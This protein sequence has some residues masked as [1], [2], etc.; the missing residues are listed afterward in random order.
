MARSF[1]LLLLGIGLGCIAFAYQ[2]WICLVA[3]LG[4]DFVILGVAHMQGAHQVFGKRADGSLPLWSW[5]IFLPM[6][7]YSLVTLNLARSITTEP[8]VSIVNDQL[9]VASRPRSGDDC[10]GFDAVI[11]LTAEFQE[12]KSV[13]KQQG[14]F[15][16]PI[17]DASAPNAEALKTAVGAVPNGRILIHCAQGHGRTGLF[18]AAWLLANGSAATAEEALCVLRNA[19]PGITLNSLQK[20]CLSEVAQLL[21]LSRN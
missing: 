11:D 13:R 19:R 15:C 12:T 9:S 18:A 21:K 17:L 20:R 7:I 16:F 14:Y 5:A 3:W 2:G 1:L 4:F 6:Q 10:S 8:W